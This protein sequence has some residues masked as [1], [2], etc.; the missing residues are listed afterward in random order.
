MKFIGAE[1][2]KMPRRQDDT[3]MEIDFRDRVVLTETQVLNVS[4]FYSIRNGPMALS[5]REH[6]MFSLTFG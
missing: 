2:L 4:A 1:N 3:N 6:L 5:A